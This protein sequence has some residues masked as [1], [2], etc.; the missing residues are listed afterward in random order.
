MRKIRVFHNP[1]LKTHGNPSGCGVPG[2]IHSRCQPPSSG[3]DPGLAPP[4]TPWVSVLG[5]TGCFPLG[6][7]EFLP[8]IP[9][10]EQ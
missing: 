10:R 3:L 7:G 4:N 6:F 5:S 1:A 2:M 8:T 9:R